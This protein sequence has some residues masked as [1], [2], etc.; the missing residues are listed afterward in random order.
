MCGRNRSGTSMDGS[1]RDLVVLGSLS[2]I[3]GEENII[4]NSVIC[5]FARLSCQGL[6]RGQRG[7]RLGEQSIGIRYITVEGHTLWNG[8]IHGRINIHWLLRGIGRRNQRIDMWQ[9]VS[10]WEV[11]VQLAPWWTSM[12]QSPSWLT[13]TRRCGNRRETP[14][15]DWCT[16]SLSTFTS[17]YT[18]GTSYSPSPSQACSWM[19]SNPIASLPSCCW[20]QSACCWSQSACCLCSIM[21]SL[22]PVRNQNTVW[23]VLQTFEA[24]AQNVFLERSCSLEG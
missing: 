13:R 16:N 4:S 6:I 20:G 17:H 5:C 1:W 19:S 9:V 14:P 22:C 24:C 21:A 10:N 11:Q 2:F 23:V 18:P 3:N 15:R 7:Y 12:L 8:L